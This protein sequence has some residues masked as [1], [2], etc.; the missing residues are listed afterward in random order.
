MRRFF[1]VI[2]LLSATTAAW[3]DRAQSEPPP[4]TPANA[5]QPTP[6]EAMQRAGGSLLR[7]TAVSMPDPNQAKLSAVSY[8]A[9]PEPVPRTLKKHD[10]VTILVHE[11]SEYKANGTT[12]LERTA[13]Y[14]AKL[15]EFLKISLKNFQVAG[16]S[17]QTAPEINGTGQRDFKG[18]ADV[19]RSDSMTL[20]VTAEVIDV[21]PNGTLALQA[22]THIKNDEED[23]TVILSGIC[24]VEDVTPDNT[25]ISTQMYDTNLTKLTTGAVRD[26][27]RRSWAQKLLDVFNPF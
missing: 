5:P 11:Q 2:A 6:A 17:P 18:S 9:V 15:S 25:V 8:F 24:R 1:C 27:N 26:T 10:L 3:G 7:A 20:R 12:D 22:R 19:D 23:Q 16:V 13:D 4:A 14:D 21:K